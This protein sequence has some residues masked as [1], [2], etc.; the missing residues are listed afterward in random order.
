M[1]F[2]GLGITE[3]EQGT[4]GVTCLI[5]LALLTGN[6]GK[7]GTGVN[8]LRGQNNVQGS[9]VMGCEP[10][11]LTGSVPFD[12]SKDVFETVWNAPIPTARGLDAIQMV[13]AAR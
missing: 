4:D 2:H 11:R 5:N 6:V 13:E 12:E 8:P 1:C 7:P 9:A 3:H 10:N